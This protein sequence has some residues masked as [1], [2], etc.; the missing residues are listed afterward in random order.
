[1]AYNYFIP[2]IHLGPA[3]GYKYTQILPLE[4]IKSIIIGKYAEFEI[5]RKIFL[6]N[7]LILEKRS[8][9]HFKNN[10]WFKKT[11]SFFEWGPSKDKKHI[12]YIE[13]QINLLK[14]KGLKS[15]SVPGFYV[16]YTHPNFKNYLSCSSE[17]Y[18]N[19][20]VISQMKHFGL[21]VDGYP[22]I[23]I[24]KDKKTTYSIVIVNPYKN[25][26]SFSLEISDLNIKKI[27]KVPAFSAKRLNMFPLIKKNSWTGQ[28][29]LYG[30]RRA[31]VYVVNH[32]FDD[33]NKISTIEHSDPFRAEPT[34]L[35]RFQYFRN[36]VHKKIKMLFN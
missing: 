12:S 18:G 10:S 17:K 36:K 35:P 14:G 7:E 24:N 31:I 23:N 32:A 25:Q 20:R 1:M 21:W 11:A 9:I 5:N 30:K 6:N 19:P 28:F 4:R 3:Y 15:T 26:S 22:A 34:Y 27:V 13:T 8:E 29:Y 2:I 33:F 16:N